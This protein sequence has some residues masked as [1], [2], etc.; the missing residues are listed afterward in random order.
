VEQAQLLAEMP[1][2]D[3]THL[4][5]VRE[6]VAQW[7]KSLTNP[8]EDVSAVGGREQELIAKERLMCDLLEMPRGQFD[9]S[10]AEVQA[11][12]KL[13]VT[14]LVTMMQHSLARSEISQAWAMMFEKVEVSKVV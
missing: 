12:D 11:M 7:R 3:V 4:K 8:G 14:T 2:E 5:N 9:H 1:P 6:I 10:H 13:P